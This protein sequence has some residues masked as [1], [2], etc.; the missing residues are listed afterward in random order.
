MGDRLDGDI[1]D[2]DGL[3]ANL[4]AQSG[5]YDDLLALSER[6][7]DAIG[8]DDL[9][10]LAQIVAAKER[11]VDRAQALE[12]VREAACAAWAKAWGMAAPPTIGEV[13]Q[14]SESAALR[15]RLKAAA[16]ALSDRVSRLR[17]SNAHN[18]HLIAQMQR[19]SEQLSEAALR[20]AQC[21][22]YDQNGDAS[23]DA[24]PGIVLDYRV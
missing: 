16:L 14:R 5:L 10:A 1:A 8:R 22:V 9:T 15:E 24:R 2:F 13:R 19:M 12:R 23:S 20:H 18:A 4:E 3:L 6:E 17:R 11:I 21:P 7:R